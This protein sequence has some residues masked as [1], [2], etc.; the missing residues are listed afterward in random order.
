MRGSG[1]HF[2]S[3][4]RFGQWQD[5][6]DLCPQFAG[7]EQFGE[8]IQ[9]GRGD[10][11]EK[12]DDRTWIV[13]DQLIGI[14]RHHCYQNAVRFEH[15]QRTVTRLAANHV[16][17]GIHRIQSVL[18]TFFFVV[19]Q[20]VRLQ[21]AQIVEIFGGGSGHHFYA[22]IF[23]KLDGVG[24]D[25]SRC[26]VNQGRL[27]WLEVSVLEERLVGGDSDNGSGSRFQEI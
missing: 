4:L 9:P 6:A 16:D 24:A 23:C 18:E 15:Q 14:R 7:V 3:L 12:K 8:H 25:I 27:T 17:D 19:D 21:I 5:G 10:F 20:L 11:G 22:G 26:T 2:V 13:T 1:Q